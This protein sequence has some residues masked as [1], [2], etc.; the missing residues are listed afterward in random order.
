MKTAFIGGGNM[1]EAMLS[2]I[3]EKGLGLPQDIVVSDTDDGRRQHIEQR[4]GVRT[5][6]NNQLAVTR[7]EVVVL[8]VKPQNLAQVMTELNGQLKP[9][10]LVLSIIAGASIQTL[11]SGLNHNL[12]VRSM[13]NTPTQIGRGITAWSAAPEVTKPQKDWVGSMF[14]TMGREIYVDDEKYI[15]M[16]TAISGSGPAYFF[17]FVELLTDAAVEIGLPHDTA[18]EL[19]AQTMLGAAHL[20]EESEHDPAELRGM[21]TSPGGTTAEAITAFEKGNL[22]GLFQQ[23]VS[24]AYNRAKELGNGL[25]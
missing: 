12:I 4:Y 24:A 21:V 7:A 11:S 15:D 9:T 1:G 3:L 6:G 20:I 14:G 23:A 17:F 5:S 18:H 8:A 10:Q 2:A 16:A 22:A 19:A 25:R 13:P